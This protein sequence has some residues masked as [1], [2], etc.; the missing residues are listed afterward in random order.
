M[1]QKAFLTTLTL[2]TRLFFLCNSKILYKY[3]RGR[4]DEWED[5]FNIGNLLYFLAVN[6]INGRGLGDD[7]RKMKGGGARGRT[8]GQTES[9]DE[10]TNARTNART[11]ERTKT[12]RIR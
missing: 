7:E 2:K 12:G 3:L 5:D 9:T 6:Y 1:V 11:N 10:R 4:E 8:R